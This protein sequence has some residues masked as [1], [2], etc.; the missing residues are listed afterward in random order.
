MISKS[1]L[2]TVIADQLKE[3]ESL[4]DS[5]PRT[6]FS[7]AVS[8]SGASAFV[9]KGVRRCGKSTLL[10][11][12]IKAKFEND[13]FYFN[14][15]D[16]RI[17]DFKSEDFQP[18]M[19]TLIEA[20][21]EKKNVFF[22]EIQNIKGW[23]LFVNRILR[24]GYKVFI[25]GS[26][27]NLL[28]K[29]LGTHLTGRHVDLELY[30]FSFAEFL[31]AKKIEVPKK[32]IYSTEQK[33]LFSKEF[34]EYFS[35]G[36]MPEAVVFSNE[37]VLTTLL[38]DIIRKDI[39][40][41]YDIRKPS[42]LK[43]VLKFLIANSANPITYRSIKNNFDIQSANTI[44]KYIEYAEETY[45]VFTVRRFEKKIKRFDKNPK[46]IYCIDNGVIT[47]NTPSITEKKGAL[48]E[49][50]VAVHLKR[51]G[52]EFYYFKTRN[53]EADFVVPAEK[54]AIQVCYEL[55]NKNK[56]RETKGLIEATHETKATSGLILTLE[57]EQEITIQNKKIIVKPVWQWLLEKES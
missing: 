30:P 56:E 20:F 32:G 7:T 19:E 23:E 10:K 8:Y 1:V 40:E 11:Q 6:V 4:K 18:L 15:D 43:T 57:Q 25:T 49:N 29:E 21:G 37:A 54:Q 17:E 14:F 41:R 51:L 16:E 12:L 55:D 26:N 9:V 5:V 36:G 28:S 3:M 2:R 42:E 24:Q 27:A 50:M 44:Q 53:S 39:S 22:D 13:F 34:K 48:L 52:K 35:K 38:T 31:R 47:K 45:L 33:A 46:K